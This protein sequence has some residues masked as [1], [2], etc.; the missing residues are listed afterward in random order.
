MS[1]ILKVLF[2]TD[3]FLELKNQIGWEEDHIARR[4]WEM[5][6]IQ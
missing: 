6:M 4:Q 5:W 1:E 3:Q 2:Q